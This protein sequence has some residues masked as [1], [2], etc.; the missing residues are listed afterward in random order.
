MNA[1]L[2][3]LQENGQW[4]SAAGTL[5]LAVITLFLLLQNRALVKQNRVMALRNYQVELIALVIDP[6]LHRVREVKEIL[7][8]GNYTY[9]DYP[10]N[11]AEEIF[12]TETDV[13]R[14]QVTENHYCVPYP[15]LELMD[16]LYLG[17]FESARFSDLKVGHSKNIAS[18]IETFDQELPPYRKSLGQL[19]KTINDKLQSARNL[20]GGDEHIPYLTKILFHKLLFQKEKDFARFLS[21]FPSNKTKEQAQRIYEGHSTALEGILTDSA[22]ICLRKEVRENASLLR[23]ELEV[24]EVELS[25]ARRRYITEYGIPEAAISQAKERHRARRLDLDII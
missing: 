5:V 16:E 4:I 25:K 15:H 3:F 21:A 17:E 12:G 19:A 11:I 23:T 18:G 6:L 22:V 20:S 9:D 2:V 7:A 1:L 14:F 13:S 8:T 10:I 24:L